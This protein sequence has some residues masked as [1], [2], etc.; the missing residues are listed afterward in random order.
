MKDAGVQGLAARGALGDVEVIAQVLEALE[1]IRKGGVVDL[2][3]TLTRIRANW[4]L[5]RLLPDATTIEDLV[6][7]TAARRGRA[8]QLLPFDFPRSKELSGMWLAL[9]DLD[10][11][12]YP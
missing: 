12:V 5:R 8:I 4:E 6:D 7:R 11:V 2:K 9:R 1:M 3:G 10:V